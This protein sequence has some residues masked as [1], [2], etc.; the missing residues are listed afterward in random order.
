MVDQ[1]KTKQLEPT[2]VGSKAASKA[3]NM[4]NC[5]DVYRFGE[6]MKENRNNTLTFLFRCGVVG[7]GGLKVFIYPPAV[8]TK[9]SGDEVRIDTDLCILCTKAHVPG[10]PPH[11]GVL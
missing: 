4:F 8:W 5:F 2:M 11:N 9:P 7:G 3:C 6:E 10:C 1:A